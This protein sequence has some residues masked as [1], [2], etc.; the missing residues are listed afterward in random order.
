M[1][2]GVIADVTSFSPFMTRADTV[3]TTLLIAYDSLST[4]KLLYGVKC[5][6]VARI[7]SMTPSTFRIPLTTPFIDST[8]LLC[9]PLSGTPPHYDLQAVCCRAYRKRKPTENRQLTSSPRRSLTCNLLAS[10]RG[11]TVN[12]SRP[13]VNITHML[14]RVNC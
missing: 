2:S 8:Q 3:A 14:Y 5:H 6:S 7:T 13:H 11:Q 12:R 4:V 9:H 1:P 10:F